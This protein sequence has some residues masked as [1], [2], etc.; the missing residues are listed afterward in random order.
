MYVSE[1]LT[2]TAELGLATNPTAADTIVINGVTYTFVSTI[3]T[4][5]GN[6]LIGA[7]VDATRAN[8]A[9]AINNPDTTSTTQVA[10]SSADQI[11]MAPFTATNDDTTDVLSINGLG[12]GAL[13]LSETL[14]DAT[15][16]WAKNCIH[17]YFGKKGAIDVAVQ[18]MKEVDMRPTSDRRGTNVFS[19]YL[20]GIKTFTD[21][22]KK[23][24]DVLLA[25]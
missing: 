14:T 18:D 19:S 13:T 10:L 17:A 22:S 9:G 2:A 4:A 8:L 25:K 12:T 23:F 24:L 11:K 20:A 21:G 16:T 15:D 3:G 7:N 6:V 5:A 1:N